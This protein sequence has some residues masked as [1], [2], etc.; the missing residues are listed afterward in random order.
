MKFQAPSTK[1]QINS[2]SQL[3]NGQAA[4]CAIIHNGLIIWSL[5]LGIYL[6]IGAWNLEFLTHFPAVSESEVLNKSIAGP[7][8]PAPHFGLEARTKALINF[9]STIGAM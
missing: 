1:S 7:W 5:V 2:K 3:P 4:V 8:P 9:P 6:V